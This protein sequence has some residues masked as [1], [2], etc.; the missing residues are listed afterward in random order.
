GA[1]APC[2][3]REAAHR[4]RGNPVLMTRVPLRVLL[5]DEGFVSGSVTA[6]A[7]RDA[8][9]EVDVIAATGGRGHCTG[10]GVAWRLAPRIGDDR[11]DQIIDRA[12]AAR[13]YD[14]VYPLTEPF[15]QAIWDRRPPWTSLVF[16]SVAA[17]DRAL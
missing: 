4:R 12:V 9:C 8:G 16:P 3:R 1:A 10:S 11:L 13:N 2:P 6:T 7:L 17:E 14:I 5:L 15:Q